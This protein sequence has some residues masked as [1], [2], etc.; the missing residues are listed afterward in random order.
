MI[1]YNIYSVVRTPVTV[2]HKEAKRYISHGKPTPDIYSEYVINMN[3]RN[4]K[5]HNDIEAVMT[6]EIFKHD[7]ERHTFGNMMSTPQISI[8][9]IEHKYHDYF[10]VDNTEI[11]DMLV[12]HVMN[13]G[14]CVMKLKTTPFTVAGTNMRFIVMN[15]LLKYRDIRMMISYKRD[16]GS[17]KASFTSGNIISL[18]YNQTELN[19]VTD[20]VVKK[21][22]RSILPLELEYR[23]DII[24]EHEAKADILAIE[25]IMGEQIV[26]RVPL[27]LNF[28]AV[29]TA[30]VGKSFYVEKYQDI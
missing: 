8:F 3:L 6:S 18:D 19:F 13:E 17:A 29:T 5:Y 27:V 10:S 9:N 4:I 22:K 23:R 21:T 1:R 16:E 11:T 26:G 24:I 20:I 30:Y 28:N 14:E 25:D 2:V 7:I 12:S 15:N